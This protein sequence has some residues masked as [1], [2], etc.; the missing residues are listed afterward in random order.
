MST[1]CTFPSRK[2]SGN[3]TCQVP[4]SGIR[5]NGAGNIAKRMASSFFRRLA[6]LLFAK[7][8]SP[9]RSEHIGSCPNSIARWSKV[10]FQDGQCAYS[11]WFVGT[12]IQCLT[13]VG[14][15]CRCNLYRER[16]LLRP[17]ISTSS[18]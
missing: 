17:T 15:E 2:S 6:R 8:S 13:D 9:T 12:E 16:N 1:P 3:Y 5:L 7:R 14:I 4:G 11:K 18:S 10:S